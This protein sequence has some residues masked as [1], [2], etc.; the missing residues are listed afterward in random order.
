MVL[1]RDNPATLAH[2]EA[3][4]RPASFADLEFPTTRIFDFVEL[5]YDNLPQLLLSHS[6]A[7][8]STTTT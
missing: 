4:E 7:W 5:S 3:F 6:A 8:F 2:N 1:I